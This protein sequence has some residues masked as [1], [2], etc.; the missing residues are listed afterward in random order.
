MTAPDKLDLK[1][2]NI[3][4]TQKEK[5][6]ELFPEVFTEGKIDF[7]KLKLTLGEDIDPL[8]E[9]FGLT[10]T[11]KAGCYKVIQEGEA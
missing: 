2:M 11:G 1:T 8:E 3:T 7:E 10:W 6:K 5:L 9:R 4:E